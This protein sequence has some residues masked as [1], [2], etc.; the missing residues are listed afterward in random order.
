[1]SLWRDVI[2]LTAVVLILNAAAGNLLALAVT[3]VYPD[4]DPTE[5]YVRIIAVLTCATALGFMW[6]YRRKGDK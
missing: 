5:L 3:Q 1:M 2:L 6:W 4:I